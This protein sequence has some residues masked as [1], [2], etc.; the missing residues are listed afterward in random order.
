MR[1]IVGERV[2]LARLSSKPRMTQAALATR[3]QLDGWDADRVVV[4]KIE[5]GLREV[6]DYELVRLA[7]ALGVSAGW[8]VG[9]T[10]QISR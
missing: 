5:I 7:K 1:N 3:L 4:A 8:L 6:T 10:D 9:E 2:R